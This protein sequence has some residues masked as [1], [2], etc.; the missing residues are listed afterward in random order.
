[1][2][3]VLI[4]V[5]LAAQAGLAA[6]HEPVK[7]AARGAPGG[8]APGAVSSAA[9]L[10]HIRPAVDFALPDTSGRAVR[11]SE[12]RG[13]VVLVSFVY[14]TCTTACPLLTARMAAL[15]ARLE[16][17]PASRSGRPPVRFVTITVDPARDSAESLARY[18]AQFRAN[19]RTWSFLR[20]EPASLGPV[21][22]AYD[23]WTRPLP[24]GEIDHPARIYL[25]DPRGDVREIYALG[26]FDD[27]QAWL[28]IQA[29]RA[30]AATSGAGGAG[31]AA[32]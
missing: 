32:R 3:V 31:K 4:A 22:A 6:A 15:Q 21:L 13:Q 11:L 28:D 23:E 29:L 10:G 17:A 8:A 18:A 9:A 30:E 5:A 26:F 16:R 24:T 19:L 20:D 1:M 7:P 14:T 25:I 2:I 27:R 12:L